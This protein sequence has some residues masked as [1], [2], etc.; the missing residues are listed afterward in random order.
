MPCSYHLEKQYTCKDVCGTIS[1]K[2]TTQKLSEH[3]IIAKWVLL[4]DI[5][6]IWIGIKLIRTD[7][8]THF[9]GRSGKVYCTHSLLIMFFSHVTYIQ[10]LFFLFFVTYH[11]PSSSVTAQE[12]NEEEKWVLTV[13]GSPV[14]LEARK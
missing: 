10:V 12:I 1:R 9:N 13:D 2:Q 11:F 14:E 3:T 8:E 4:K 7:S 5:S 6:Q